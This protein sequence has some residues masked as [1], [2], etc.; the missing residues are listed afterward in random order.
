MRRSRW[1]CQPCLP[2]HI[3]PSKDLS[4]ISLAKPHFSSFPIFWRAHICHREMVS[5]GLI[6]VGARQVAILDAA[7]RLRERQL[8]IAVDLANEF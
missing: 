5:I 1:N 4:A 2:K 6:T 3:I 8:N 7:H